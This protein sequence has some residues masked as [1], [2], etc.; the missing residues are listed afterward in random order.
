V[1]CLALTV[2]VVDNTI[3]AV[4]FPSIQRGLGTDESGLQWIGSSYGLVLAGLLL[5]LAVIGDRHGR[6]R[7]LMIGLTI[8][9]VASVAGAFADSA[10][11]LTVARGLMGIG[12]ACA[13]PATLSTI[14]NVFPEEER[15]QAIAVWSGVAGIATAAGPV[16]GGVLLAHF[17]WGSVFLVNVPIVLITLVLA[18]WWVPASRDAESPR[19]DTRS[20]LC[21]WGAL[22]AVILAVIEGPQLGWLSPL[23][24]GSALVGVLLLVAF[25]RNEA[26]SDGPLIDA[27]T[28][29]DPRLLWG[30]AT[31]S[32]LFFA[33]FGSQFVIT[34]WIQG[35]LGE[36]A[37]V[38]GLFFVP[39]AVAAMITAVCNPRF[40]RA[41]GHGRVAASGLGATAL[42]AML[43]AGAVAIGSLEVVAVAGLFLG[44]GIGT[45]SASGAEL[46]MSSA[47]PERAGS[48][49][50]VN[51]ALVEAAGALG[52]AVLGSVLVET[53]SFGWPLPVAAGV[54]TLVGIGV[55]RGLNPRRAARRSPVAPSP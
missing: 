22:T 3:L 29:R 51:E 1:L 31:M 49:S 52:I 35:P 9:G 38:A 50:G 17:W 8:F 26:R 46:I 25:T 4:A 53:G 18:A 37:I 34:Q 15:G 10:A 30:A 6:K 33:V 42:G 27:A 12:G 16:I 32:A 45:A 5:P 21:W 43:A 24:V 14:G 36:S 44:I 20:A 55:A 48:A 28:R 47:P 39:A 13:M 41:Y 11:A 40:V 54:A 23:V 19:V 7:M 2:V